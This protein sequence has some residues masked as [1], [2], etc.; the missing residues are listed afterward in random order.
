MHGQIVSGN[1]PSPE[2]VEPLSMWLYETGM[3]IPAPAYL[4]A[5]A[6]SQA[7]SRG[8]VSAW[9][10]WDLLLTPALA[11]RPVRH[12]EIDPCGEDPEREFA[13]GAEF[14]PYTP[15]FNMTG[16][17]A[18]SVPLFHGDDGLPT[19]AQIVG[20]QA[21]EA[22]LLQVARQLE[23]IRPWAHRFPGEHAVTKS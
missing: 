13:K 20:P 1:V 21:G 9:A 7:I 14:T 2:N 17:P 4:G 19:A 18:V 8:I 12:A 15:A 22:L 23:E 10:D 5:L 16:Q 6:M 11:Q 3:A